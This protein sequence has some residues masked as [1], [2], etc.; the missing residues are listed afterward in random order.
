MSVAGNYMIY[1]GR[2]FDDLLRIAS[3]VISPRRILM[4]HTLQSVLIKKPK[5][6]KTSHTRH[7]E[8]RKLEKTR[9]MVVEALLSWRSGAQASSSKPCAHP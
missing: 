3:G 8:L 2:L 7:A 1:L 6:L 9:S 5:F 4:A